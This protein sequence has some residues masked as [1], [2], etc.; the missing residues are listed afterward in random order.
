MIKKNKKPFV[1]LEEQ[2]RIHKPKRGVLDQIKDLVDWRKINWQL[3]R[4]YK[5]DKGRPAISPLGMFK[6]LLLE[7]FYD[8]S[9]VRAVEELHDRL[10]FQRFT[11]IGIYEHQVDSSSLV[12]FRERLMEKNRME[13]VFKLFNEQ[14][15]E[16]GLV[17]KKGTIIDST[18]VKGH[19][20][21]GKT[22][23]DGSVL[24]PDAE[25]TA[26]DGQV[27]DGY[28]VSISVDEGS[29]LIREVI[30]T[31]AATHDAVLFDPLVI[32]DEKKVYADKG[33]ASEFNRELLACLWID[34]GI[35]HKGYR[36]KPLTG[37]QVSLN[38]KL[39]RHRAA[40]ERKFG[41]A[42]E[43]HGMRRFRYLGLARNRIQA[44]VTALVMNMKRMVKLKKLVY[45]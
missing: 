13:K 10:S 11:E 45:A 5:R 29:E 35:C 19:H 33:Y 28:K 7:Q 6:L 15:E 18:L 25:W 22:G 9:D 34:D 26:R 44:Y 42:K 23:G 39:N 43:R 1:P 31:G 4:M 16:Q 14:L 38:K 17:L 37:W 20:R 41:E 12:R 24:D 2:W 36:N 30:V 21:P 3:E 40:V 27:H 32:G 8:L